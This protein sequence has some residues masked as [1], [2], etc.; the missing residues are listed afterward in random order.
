[1]YDDGYSFSGTGLLAVLI[2]FTLILFS[3]LIYPSYISG[4]TAYAGL[5]RI[6][7]N[8]LLASSVTGY[9]D[10]TGTLGPVTV[11]NPRPTSTRLG[12]VGMRIQL[13]SIRL[14]WQT[15]SGID[16]DQTRVIF[17]SPAGSESLTRNTAL[18]FK[19]QGWAIVSKESM[20]PFGQANANNIIEPNEAFGIFIYPSTPLS[21]GTPFSIILQMPDENVITINRTV[22]AKITTVMNLG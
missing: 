1:M 10:L 2:L 5:Q 19:K 17:V 7:D 3:L 21:P 20:L 12:A 8:P 16:L 11:V 9:A 6:T 4:K 15:G 18:P 13:A 22:P 14:G